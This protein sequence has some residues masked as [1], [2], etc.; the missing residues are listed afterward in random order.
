MLFEVEDR[1]EVTMSVPRATVFFSLS[2][3]A[4]E[5]GITSN[6]RFHISNSKITIHLVLM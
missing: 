1:G 2:L 3:I 6:L 5:A 4:G